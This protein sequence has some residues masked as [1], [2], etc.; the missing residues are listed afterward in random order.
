[1]LD[2][3][4]TTSEVRTAPN[5]RQWQQVEHEAIRQYANF[6]SCTADPVS[7]ATSIVRTV[8]WS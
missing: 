5:R 8:R 2:A 6:F 1:M 4:G 7:L 3:R